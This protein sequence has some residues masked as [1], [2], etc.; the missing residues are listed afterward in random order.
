MRPL[1]LLD[2]PGR[3]HFSDSDNIVN[4][5]ITEDDGVFV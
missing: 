3:R 5:I 4:H 2:Q 1:N